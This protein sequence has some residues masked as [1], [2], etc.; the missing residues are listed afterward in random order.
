[1]WISNKLGKRKIIRDNFNE[2]SDDETLNADYENM[3]INMENI[4]YNVTYNTDWNSSR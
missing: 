4:G 2:K 3:D 1:S